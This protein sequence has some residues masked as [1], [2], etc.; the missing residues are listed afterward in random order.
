MQTHA[1]S[2]NSLRI[3]VSPT[4]S[5]E[6]CVYSVKVMNQGRKR[7]YTIQKFTVDS[8]FKTLTNMKQSLLGMLKFAVDN[9]GYI[10]PGHGLKGKQQWIVQDEDLQEILLQ[11]ARDPALVYSAVFR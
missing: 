9:F 8:Q 11:T 2:E 1:E 5:Q 4:K 10:E 3:S 7:E 6:T